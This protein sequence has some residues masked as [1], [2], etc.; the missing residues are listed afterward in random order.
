MTSCI[1]PMSIGVLTVA[2]LCNNPL[3]LRVQPI[4]G[5]MRVPKVAGA[6]L[7]HHRQ[8]ILNVACLGID[9]SRQ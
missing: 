2:V 8:S 4:A 9:P 7:T 6:G 1:S 5:A 3:R